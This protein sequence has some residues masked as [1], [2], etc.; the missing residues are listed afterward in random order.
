M[1]GEARYS[2][3][4]STTCDVCASGYTCAPGSTNPQQIGREAALG[5]YSVNGTVYNCPAGTY[6]N[7]TAAVSQQDGCIVCEE[8]FYCLEGSTPYTKVP[9]PTGAY[10]PRG[11]SY[12]AQYLCPAGKYNAIAGKAKLGDCLLCK[13]G[14][15]CPEGTSN[16][17]IVPAGYYGPPGTAAAHEHS[18][19][20]GRYSNV[21]GL[22]HADQCLQCE[23]GHYW[24]VLPVSLEMI[25][26][27]NECSHHQ[28]TL[29]Y[30]TLPYPTLP[31]PVLP[32]P[33]LHYPILSI[34]YRTIRYHPNSLAADTAPRA[35]PAGR[36]SPD[37]GGHA[38]STCLNCP[39]GRACPYVG[40]IS[41]SFNF[42]R[43]HSGHY[44][45]PATVNPNDNPCPAGRYTNATNL[46]DA[47]QCDICPERVACHSGTGGH[48][49]L[50]FVPCAAGHWCGYGT[51]FAAQHDCPLGRYSAA[52]NLRHQD[53]CR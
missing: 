37:Q 51:Q 25:I 16:G 35:C 11:T 31:C 41:Y 43:C 39:A 9:C 45:P 10:C 7:R 40:M 14:T 36:Y 34:S 50:Q 21:A 22:Y 53:E 4:G 23:R 12:A 5:K 24:L 8:S 1:C 17:D 47:T 27:N 42:S 48:D 32:Y 20:A 29:P 2:Y 30:P 6:G 28:S 44:C 49:A 26:F 52:T 13:N 19:P 38:L 33:T 3:L 46:I 18:C 15:Y